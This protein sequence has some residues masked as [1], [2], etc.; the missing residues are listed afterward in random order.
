[1][2]K[3]LVDIKKDLDQKKVFS[4]EEAVG[5]IQQNSKAKF[6]ESIDISMNLNIDV[7]KTDQNIRGSVALP[8]GTGKNCIV[9]VFAKDAKA[10][11]AKENGADIVGAEDL[12]ERIKKGDISFDACIATPDM[13]GVVGQVARILGPRGLMPNPKLGTVTADVSSIIASLKAGRVNY[14]NDKAGVVHA[15]VGKADFAKKALIEN[16]NTFIKN[17]VN[18]K[19]TGSKGK[20]V[21]SMY[22]SST[23]GA[24]VM[25]EVN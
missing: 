20:F 6:V 13:M 18:N 4:L 16:I 25:F 9:A 21:K 7:S 12:V 17:I 24:S 11:E 23:Q 2:G 8:N 15:I 14:R 1:M 5:V 19:P 3:R 10:K 22:L